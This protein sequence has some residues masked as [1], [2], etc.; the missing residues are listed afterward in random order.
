MT[1]PSVTGRRARSPGQFNLAATTET[2][3]YITLD[4][5]LQLL[6]IMSAHWFQQFAGRFG[7]PHNYT[8]IDL[9]TNGV[10]PTSSQICSIGHT[11][12]RDGVP[13]ETKEVYLNWPDFPDIDHLAFQRD[14]NN[15][16]RGMAAQGKPFHHTWDRLQS[17]G[18]PPMDVLTEY[19]EMFEAMEGRREVVVAH[20]GFRFDIELL[21]AH[22]HNWLD[23]PFVFDSALVYDTGIAEKA[24]QLD[25][26]DDPLPLVGETMQQFAW[27]I[28][29]LRRRGVYW[30]LD[31]HCDEKYRLFE[32]AST[33]IDQAHSAGTDS[34]VL[35]YLVEEH[36][37]LAGVA[38]HVNLDAAGQTLPVTPL[39]IQQDVDP[40]A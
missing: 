39:N 9:E 28:G 16:E 13:I 20:N 21:Q 2:C 33:A 34:L 3:R 25:E 14:L 19:L 32:K 17:Q 12:V 15:A 40:S 18:R 24:S 30:A 38:P 10:K 31:R 27:R 11:I 8:C 6:S 4:R 26:D 35:A 23:I 1:I 22:F 5:R 29:A 36:K 37:K 7:F